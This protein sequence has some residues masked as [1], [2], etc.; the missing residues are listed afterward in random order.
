LQE[1]K[2]G[3]QDSCATG[4]LEIEYWKGVFLGSALCHAVVKSKLR[5]PTRSPQTPYDFNFGTGAS[6][7]GRTFLQIH[8]LTKIF[9]FEKI[10]ITP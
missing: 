1:L 7:W 5:T 4:V 2:T 6:F 3:E 9:T 8:L 10:F